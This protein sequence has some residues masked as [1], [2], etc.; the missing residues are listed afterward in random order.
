MNSNKEEN[1]I[2][3]YVKI[4]DYLKKIE[5]DEVSFQNKMNPYHSLTANCFWYMVSAEYFSYNFFIRNNPLDAANQVLNRVSKI[6]IQMS[7]RF[8]KNTRQGNILEFQTEQVKKEAE[9]LT[10]YLSQLIPTPLSINK[11]EAL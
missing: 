1:H 11:S 10:D 3:P 5:C 9:Q 2:E 4:V 8:I 7:T 6:P